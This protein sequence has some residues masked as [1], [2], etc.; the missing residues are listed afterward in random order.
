MF[1]KE[2]LIKHYI[3]LIYDLLMVVVSFYIANYIRFGALNP[4][5]YVDLFVQVLGLAV[6]SCLVGNRL[7]RLDHKVFDRGM[8]AE[9]IAVIKG[10]L[11]IAVPVLFYLYF[12]KEAINY[13]RLQLGYFFV[14]YFL[15]SYFGRLIMKKMVAFYYRK[16]RS[17]KQVLLVTSSE[18][19]DAILDKFETTNNWFFKIAYIVLVDRDAKGETIRDIP[20]IANTDDMLDVCTNITLDDVFLNIGYGLQKKFDVV[21]MLHDFQNMGVLVHVNVDA[22]ELDITNKKLENLGFFKVV[23]YSSNLY[24]PGQLVIKRLM[25]IAGAI[26]GLVIT[27][28]VGLFVV[29]AI[30]L[31]SKGP[32]IYT[33]T[34]VGKN[35][36]HFKMY[37][38]RSMYQDADKR[39]VELMSQNE[40]Q[41]AMFKMEND[42]RIT[43]VGKFIRKH[44]IDELPQ[45][46][47]ILKGDM[48]LV[49]TRPPTVDEVE[50]YTTGQKRRL[51]VTP[52]LTGL[53]QVS[54]RS[55]ILDFDEI[56]KLD[57][58][59]IDQWSIGLDIKLIFKTVAVMFTGDGAK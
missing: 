18:K 46:F 6:V 7:F 24:E 1:Q 49:G 4:Q 21:K 11:C 25:D 17:Y 10:S 23:T 56:V 3:F 41:G 12:S 39:K 15:L 34:R 33:S 55:D 31:E 19:V 27:F 44:S 37:K 47:N 30:K 42:P 2:T 13:A 54:G 20:V 35:G 40:M 43:K 53:W 32:A 14:I 16:S 52:G 26:V 8:F 5:E 57:L 51:S 29:P 22:L 38:F 48:S 28:I 59:Y 58:E 45:F 50:Q 36:R 9:L